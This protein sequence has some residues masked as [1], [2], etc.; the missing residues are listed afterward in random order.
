MNVTDAVIKTYLSFLEERL[1]DIDIPSKRFINL[2]K[3]EIN[4][5]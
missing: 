1:L 3:D 4:A 2:T 5:M